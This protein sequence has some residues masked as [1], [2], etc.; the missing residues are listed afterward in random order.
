MYQ[1]SGFIQFV[2]VVVVVVFWGGGIFLN[3]KITK[4]ANRKELDMTKE[5]PLKM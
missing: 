2:V 1:G 4:S 3:L 5:L